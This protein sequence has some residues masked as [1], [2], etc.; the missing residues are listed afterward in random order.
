[1]ISTKRTP[2]QDKSTNKQKKRAMINSIVQSSLQKALMNSAMSELKVRFMSSSTQ[3]T[4]ITDAAT[5]PLIYDATP[6]IAQGSGA[7]NRDGNRITIKKA[8]LGI[9][10]SQSSVSNTSSHPWVVDVVIGYQKGDPNNPPSTAGQFNTLYY[11]N[12]AAAYT[13]SISNDSTTFDAPFNENTW[14]VLHS[15]RHYIGQPAVATSNQFTAQPDFHS[16][17]DLYLDSTS[18]LPKVVTFQETTQYPEN[19]HGPYVWFFIRS[20]L[21]WNTYSANYPL[22]LVTHSVDYKDF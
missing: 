12:A 1:V 7:G 17:V 16:H 21:G 14:K 20:P 19:T 3:T 6:T 11:D 2:K 4:I 18:W 9:H 13:T 15:S 5:V 22:V 10:I 8:K